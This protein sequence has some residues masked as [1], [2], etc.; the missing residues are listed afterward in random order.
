[1]K[2]STFVLTMAT[3]L[4]S[5]VLGSGCSK[6]KSGA[7]KSKSSK[8][9]CQQ[10]GEKMMTLLPKRHGETLNAAKFAK[11]CE[12]RKFSQARIQCTLKAETLIDLGKC[13]SL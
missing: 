10:L 12:T 11:L 2:S 4:A 3:L 13:R 9:T 8:V 1:M 6:D 7:A 5:L